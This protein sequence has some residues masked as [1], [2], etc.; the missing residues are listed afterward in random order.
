V[1]NKRKEW[2]FQSVAKFGGEREPK[3]E[4]TWEVAVSAVKISPCE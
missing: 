3:E 4:R 2:T 1:A